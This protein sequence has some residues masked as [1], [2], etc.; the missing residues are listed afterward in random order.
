MKL[1][2]HSFS[3]KNNEI[4]YF[5]APEILQSEEDTK[6]SDVYSFA[7]IVYEMMYDEKPFCYIQNQNQ[8]FVEVVTKCARPSINESIPSVYNNLI[9]SCWS[10]NKEDRPDFNSIANELKTNR[11]FITDKID[12]NEFNNY[13]EFIEG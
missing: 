13:I 9:T 6:S 7:F 4:K 5:I 3:N 10:Q 11:Q 12:E 2:S 8:L 1:S